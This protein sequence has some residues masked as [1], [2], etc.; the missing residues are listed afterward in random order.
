MASGGGVFTRQPRAGIQLSKSKVTDMADIKSV[1]FVGWRGMV[2]SVL[3]DRMQEEGDFEGIEP[4]FYS[5][6]QAGKP[7][8]DV[9]VDAPPVKESHDIESLAT[10]DVIMTS[11][12]GD[13]TKEVYGELRKSG[14]DGYWIDA[15]SAMRMDKDS[16]IVLDPVNRHVID[17]ALKN[18]TKNFIGGN[19]TV[20]L[21]LLALQGLFD[22]DMI[23]W[24]SSMTYQA[25]SG[26]GAAAMREL[27]AQMRTLGNSAAEHLDNPSSGILALDKNVETSLRDGSLDTTQFGAPLAASLIPWIDRA[28]ELGQTREEWKAHVE[29]NKILELSPEVPI[30]GIC[31]RVSSMRCHSQAFTIKLKSGAPIDEIEEMLKGANEWVDFVPNEKEATVRDLSPAKVS[32]TSAIPIGRVRKMRMGDDYLS[33]FTVGDQLLWGAAEPIRRMLA[34]LRRQ[35]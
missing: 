13:Y 24:M 11:Q 32:G 21:M 3:M 31:V 14:W 29:A 27:V 12:G 9:G 15:A 17:K 4:V 2:G 16:V 34:I 25:A 23:E 8:P 6:S 1:G 20:S 10:H 7:A 18:G 19:C 26:A 33:A 22:E 35:L 5:T 30:D 28:V